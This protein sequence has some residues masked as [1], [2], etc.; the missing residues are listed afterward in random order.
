MFLY[1][2]SFSLS[3]TQKYKN[4]I[5]LVEDLGN[6]LISSGM[7]A[8]KPKNINLIR[9]IYSDLFKKELEMQDIYN[10]KA[11]EGEEL[12]NLMYE[13][14]EELKSRGDKE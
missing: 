9:E 13:L 7:T 4:Q 3:E 10:K 2:E 11:S 1:V 14:S 5:R 12:I 8:K 6:K